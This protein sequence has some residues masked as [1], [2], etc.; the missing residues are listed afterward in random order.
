MTEENFTSK[1]LNWLRCVMHDRMVPPWAF[2]IAYCII[3]HLNARNG[4]AFVS[5]ETLADL[6]GISGRT[7]RRARRLLRTAGWLRWKRTSTANVYEPLFGK[8]SGMMDHIQVQREERQERRER[9]KHRPKVAE[10]E[11]GDR[12]KLAEQ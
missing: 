5:D 10:H 2:E 3:S 11:P 4:R 9:R 7:V 12:T 6:S 1:K 8:I